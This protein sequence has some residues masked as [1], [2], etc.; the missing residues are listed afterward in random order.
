MPRKSRYCNRTTRSST[1]TPLF[2]AL[3]VV[4]NENSR[5]MRYMQQ[6]RRRINRLERQLEESIREVEL[7]Q[8]RT[9]DGAQRNWELGSR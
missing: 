2:E 5:L 9:T 1:N 6:F 7:W 4:Q 8:E 3:E